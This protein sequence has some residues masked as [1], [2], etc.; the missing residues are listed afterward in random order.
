MCLLMQIRALVIE[1]IRSFEEKA[2]VLCATVR[3]MQ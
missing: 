1:T 3:G 2:A